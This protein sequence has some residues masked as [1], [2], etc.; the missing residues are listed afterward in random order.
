MNLSTLYASPLFLITLTLA[1]YLAGAALN[2]RTGSS[3]ANPTL[4]AIL[5]VGLA[6]H[7]VRV[8]YATYFSGAQ[9]LHFLLGPATVALAIPLVRSLEHLR[10]SLLPTL[11]ALFAGS[12]TGAVSA[13][14]TVRVCGG[15]Q[16]LALTMLPKSLTTP[17][18]MDVS[19]T[20]GGVPSLTTVF[21]IA[22]GVMVAV[23][24]PWLMKMF[25]I[26]DPAAAGLAA[27]TSGSGIA[28][29]RVVAMGS[30]PLAFAG[31]AIGMNGLMTAA[32]APLLARMLQHLWP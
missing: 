8:P 23:A 30:V 12:V 25:R 17:I 1:A 26:E 27:G 28:T 15:N 13:Y 11:A 24:L 29:A 31:V 3:L 21:A 32:L 10:R 2:R 14:V 7:V 16:Q 22:A 19:Q 18:A 5:L 9:F 20:I 6:L 4:I